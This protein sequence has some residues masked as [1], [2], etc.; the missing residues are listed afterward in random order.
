MYIPIPK[1]GIALDVVVMIIST[2][3]TIWVSIAVSDAR[4]DIKLQNQEKRLDY[5]TGKRDSLEAELKA[6]GERTARTEEMVK[7]LVERAKLKP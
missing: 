7:F 4:T 1:K 5:N 2:G 3:V 6:V